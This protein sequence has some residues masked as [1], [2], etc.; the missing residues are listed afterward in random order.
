MVVQWRVGLHVVLQVVFT[1]PAFRGE[2]NDVER[3]L[4]LKPVFVLVHPVVALAAQPCSY[5]AGKKGNAKEAGGL[6]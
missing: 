1:E 3:P 5:Y 4:G 2:A 6:C